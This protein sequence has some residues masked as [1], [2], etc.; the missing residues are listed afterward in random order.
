MT[1]PLKIGVQLPEVERR[2]PWPELISMT[3]AAEAVGFDSVWLGDHLLYDLPDGTARGPWEVYTS[4]AALAAVTERVQLGSLVSSL[5]FHDPAMI[6]K[7]AA[8]IDAVSDGRLVLGVGSGWNEREYRAFGL[9]FDHRVDRFE[10]AFHVLRRLLAGEMVTHSGTYYAVDRCVIDPPAAR[11]GGPVLMVGSN[12]PRMLSITLPHVHSWNVWWS[13]YGNTPEGFAEV[14]ADVRARTDAVGRDPDEVEATACVYVQV[15]GGVGRTMG[16]PSM[17]RIQPL[18][19][20]PQEL[21]EQLAAFA[22]AGAAHVQL[23][24]DPITQPA[25]EWLGQVLQALD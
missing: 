10:E 21:A 5:G 12:S 13:I 4:L 15:P 7:M 18:R 24:V 9:P 19:G 11:A 25:I 6:A 3:R 20:E 1:R 14:V 2:V 8:T 23:V 22:H 17:A 16:D